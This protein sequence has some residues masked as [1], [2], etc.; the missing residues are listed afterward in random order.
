MRACLG[1]MIRDRWRLDGIGF[2]RR[3]FRSSVSGSGVV[4]RRL[5]E[6][7]DLIYVV[8]VFCCYL[9]K[10]LEESRT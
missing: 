10:R 9:E 8:R 7:R 1:K 3:L 5:K 4:G 6:E 2:C